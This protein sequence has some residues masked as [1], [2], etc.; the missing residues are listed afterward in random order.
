MSDQNTL[1]T[2]EK[3]GHGLAEVRQRALIH[4]NTKL[5]HELITLKGIYIGNFGQNSFKVRNF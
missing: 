1:R 5:E 4:L 3:L 2:I